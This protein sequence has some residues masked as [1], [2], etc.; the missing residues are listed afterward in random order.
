MMYGIKVGGLGEK[1]TKFI[2]CSVTKYLDSQMCNN[3]LPD[4]N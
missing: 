4:F 2:I 1:F 3:N